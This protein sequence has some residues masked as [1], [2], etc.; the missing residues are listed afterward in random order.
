MV[1]LKP[2]D[3]ERPMINDTK[4]IIIVLNNNQNNDWMSGK[5]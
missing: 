4:F 2:P 5:T 3:R 1:F